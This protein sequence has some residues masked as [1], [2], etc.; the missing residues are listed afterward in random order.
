M[1]ALSDVI[2]DINTNALIRHVMFMYES[3]VGR[4]VEK[5]ESEIIADDEMQALKRDLKPLIS[6]IKAGEE[7]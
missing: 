3:I 7:R 6:I 5:V 4:Q 1:F 2:E